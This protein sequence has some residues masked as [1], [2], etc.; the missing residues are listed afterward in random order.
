MKTSKAIGINHGIYPGE[1]KPLQL[2]KNSNN[3]DQLYH[4]RIAIA[5]LTNFQFQDRDST[6]ILSNG[7][8]F[9]FN[10]FS[11][12]SP[13]R[14][15]NIPSV[16]ITRYHIDHT[17]FLLEEPPPTNFTITDL[18]LFSDYFFNDTLEMYDWVS[19]NQVDGDAF[20]YFMPRFEYEVNKKIEVLGMDHVME[21]F[22]SRNVPLIDYNDDTPLEYFLNCPE[23]EWERYISKFRGQLVTNPGKKP[24]TIRLDQLDREQTFSGKD[25][26]EIRYPTIVH[27]GVRPANLSYA[28]DPVYQKVFRTYQ[29][30][31]H[32]I[33]NKPRITPEHWQKIS[34]LEVL[35]QKMRRMGDMQREI[36]AE[37]RYDFSKTSFILNG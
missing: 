6:I 25:N 26:P 3:L 33:T 12:F 15:S 29:K 16:P 17:L 2:D 8:N 4:Y 5:P 24:S 35:L 20:F 18:E 7:K 11:L 31:R 36:C 22:L 34:D 9:K 37:I 23:K 32:L 28:G 21:Y 14:L 27:F 1:S 19:K 30:L 10:G 13:R